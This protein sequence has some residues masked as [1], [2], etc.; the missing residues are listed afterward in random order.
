VTADLGGRVALVTGGGR[1]IGRAISLALL[2]R[3]ASVGVNYRRDRDAAEA[4]VN[5][6]LAMGARAAAFQ[7]SV[8]DE[9]D[10]ERMVAE[11]EAELGPVS[12]LVNNAGVAS[13]GAPVATST[14]EESIALLRTHALGPLRLCQLVLP[15]MRAAGRGDVVMISS[16][17]TELYA[18]N[19]VVYSMA[20]AAM[21]AIARTLAK[22][23]AR[24]GIRSNIV[25]P[26]LVATELGDR[27]V[28]S[29][30]GGQ[31]E[32]ADLDRRAPYG[33]VCRPEDVAE[34]VAFLVSEGGGYV[35]GQRL[36]V[37]GGAPGFMARPAKVPSAGTAG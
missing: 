23:E 19:G 22:E 3:G 28:R 7:A 17:T 21:E 2:E 10:C 12:I 25:A 32:L 6:G 34:V 37:D 31:T 4:T 1:G 20:K 33:R 24:H 18:P 35:N 27:L 16:S 9:A 15:G 5:D 8:D 11:V 13:R 26:G 36:A 29:V 14:V 30:G